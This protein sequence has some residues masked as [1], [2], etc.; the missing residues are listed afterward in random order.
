[1]AVPFRFDAVL[2]IRETE[3]DKCR[4]SLAQSQQREAELIAERTRIG[5]ERQAVLDELRLMSD[6]SGISA[7][8]MLARHQHAEHLSVELVQ[9]DEARKEVAATIAQ[10]R[11]ALLEA[12]TAVKALEKLAGRHHEEQRR[13]DLVNDERDRDD[14]HRSGRAA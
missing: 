9:I 14:S 5:E 11:A 3:R 1:M 2:R 4:M 6:G 13:I 7:E 10:C 12:D 8:R